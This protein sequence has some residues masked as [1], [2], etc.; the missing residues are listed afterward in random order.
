MDSVEVQ[1]KK[2]LDDYS[3]EVQD[4]TNGAIDSVA[5]LAVQKLKTTSPKRTGEYARSWTSK[6]ER[7][8]GIEHV[9]VHN[10]K[11]YQLTHLL[12]NGHVIRNKS[13]TFGRVDGDNHIGLVAEW[14]NSELPNEVERKL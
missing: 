12:N 4:A 14:A 8:R 10:S 7:T 3:R 1:M 13:G 11:H 2:I 9:I 5:K 6:K